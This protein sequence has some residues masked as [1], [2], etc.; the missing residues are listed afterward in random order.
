M[1]PPS[2]K[3][4]SDNPSFFKRI[5]TSFKRPFTKRNTKAV[6]TTPTSSLIITQEFEDEQLRV[7]ETPV[8]KLIHFDQESV[9]ATTQSTGAI[10]KVKQQRTHPLL[11]GKDRK[12]KGHIHI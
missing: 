8:A 7:S 6:D 3:K 4:D 12:K 11:K 2:H 1:T 5:S 10:P 9:E